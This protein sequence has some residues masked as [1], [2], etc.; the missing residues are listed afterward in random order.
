MSPQITNWKP[1]PLSKAWEFIM[2]TK[3]VA[4]FLIFL[5]H[6]TGDVTQSQI[7][8]EDFF[9]VNGTFI[10]LSLSPES[11]T[12][13]LD[14]IFSP[15]PNYSFLWIL[16]RR[17]FPGSDEKEIR[18]RDNFFSCLKSRR[19]YLTTRIDGKI[20]E[21]PHKYFSNSRHICLIYPPTLHAIMCPKR[22]KSRENK[23]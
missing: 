11:P 13:T 23:E 2:A 19:D 18:S 21:W 4:Y 9:L 20:T 17:Q 6:E 7:G 5:K 10:R 8:P 15:H 16:I 1:S 22:W 14:L 12:F 3:S